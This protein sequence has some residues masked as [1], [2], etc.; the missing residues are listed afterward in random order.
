MNFSHFLPQKNDC[1][2]HCST[3]PGVTAIFSQKNLTLAPNCLNKLIV[4]F[5][6]PHHQEFHQFLE[7]I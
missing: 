1:N 3:P 6:S 7:K 4:A 5:T 2:L